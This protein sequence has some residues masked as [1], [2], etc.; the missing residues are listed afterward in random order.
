MIRRENTTRRR[1]AF[2]AEGAT[3]LVVCGAKATEPVYFDELKRARRNPAVT[4][5]IMAKQRIRRPLSPMRPRCGTARK[6]HTT[7]CGAWST[8]TSSI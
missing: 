4:V 6:A 7:K 2:R 1:R 5:K 3:L 8:S